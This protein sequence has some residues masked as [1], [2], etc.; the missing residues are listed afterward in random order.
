MDAFVQIGLKLWAAC[1]DP[2]NATFFILITSTTI[3]GIYL[4][5]Q[6]RLPQLRDFLPYFCGTLGIF[7]TFLGIFIGLSDFDSHNI[8]Q[9]IPPLLDGMKVAFFSSIVGMLGS[10]AL[11]FAYSCYECKY[12]KGEKDAVAILKNIEISLVDTSKGM[13]ELIYTLNKCFKSDEE[14]SLVSQVRLI[15]QEMADNRKATEKAFAEF[16]EKFSQMASESLVNELRKVVDK[17]NVMLNDLVGQAFQDLK[18]STDKLNQWQAE[19]REMLDQQHQNLV[20]LLNQLSSLNTVYNESVQRLEKVSAEMD[21]IDGSLSSITLSGDSLEKITREL[22]SQ[23]RSLEASLQEIARTG[24][25]AK[26]AIP[27]ISEGF[28]LIAQQ[29]HNMQVE[30][31]KFVA[32]LGESLKSHADNFQVSCQKQINAMD[33]SIRSASNRVEETDTEHSKFVKSLISDF[34]KHAESVQ[35]ASTEQIKSI[36][37]ALETSLTKSLESFGGAMVALSNK[38]TSDYL[39]LTEKLAKI[40]RI[41]EGVR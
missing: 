6:N 37:Y 33:E 11:K 19:H 12:I 3:C 26:M 41:A 31:N 28:S 35:A 40:V 23:N 32:S 24:E 9:S 30:V 39:P 21:S 29:M 22:H 8:S 10:M 1:F 14:Y 7:G 25:Q 17:F 13:S 5:A 20:S 15:R 38:F 18:V 27:T 36:E 2:V 34:N 16:A 4:A